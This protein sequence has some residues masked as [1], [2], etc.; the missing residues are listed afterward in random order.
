MPEGL[1]ITIVIVNYR[2][3]KLTIE[4]LESIYRYFP[5]KYKVSVVIA[6]NHSQDDSVTII[7]GEIIK[8][9]W[10]SWAKILPL[11]KNGGFAYG[12]TVPWHEA[13]VL[14]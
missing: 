5:S 1:S 3:H 13:Q 4:C 6:D 2:S 10:K 8:K 12:N 14:G 11:K 7:E 9:G